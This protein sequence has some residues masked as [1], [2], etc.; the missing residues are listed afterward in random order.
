[1]VLAG[2][3]G[4]EYESVLMEANRRTGPR[5]NVIF[6][7]AL[8]DL[9]LARLI[10]KARLAVIPSLYEGFCLPL[11]ESMACGIP[12]IAANR[13]CLPEIS[14]GVLRYFDP[15]ST[16]EMAVCMEEVLES[17]ELRQ[18]LSDQGLRQAAQFDWG[19]CAE[20]TL[21]ILAQAAKSG[22]P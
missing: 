20:E 1:L 15:E 9:D 22:N 16:D 11:V 18:K 12:T 17:Q 8:S 21:T 13:S 7:Q 19:R 10:K 5:G 6:T 3:L 2:P 4:W 14:G